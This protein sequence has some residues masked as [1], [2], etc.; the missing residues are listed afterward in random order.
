MTAIFE[1]GLSKMYNLVSID[2]LQKFVNVICNSVLVST[3]LELS[4]VT[5]S[6]KR[7]IQYTCPTV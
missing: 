1:S 6:V 4:C 3:M 7:A 5:V 2:E